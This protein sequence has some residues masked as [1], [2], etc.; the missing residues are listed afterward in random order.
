MRGRIHILTV[1]QLDR[2]VKSRLEEDVRL[3]EVYV[4]GELSNVSLHYSSGHLYFTLKEDA[5]A[6]RGV[7]FR[8][9]ASRLM[10]Q[11][12][13]GMSVLVRGFVTLYERDGAYQLNI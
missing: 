9:N 8:S 7:M 10:F 11:P 6:V 3:Q 4:Q 13:N 12:E 2:Y 1:A 5:A